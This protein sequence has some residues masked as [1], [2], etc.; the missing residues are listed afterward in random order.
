MALKCGMVKEIDVNL[1]LLKMHVQYQESDHVLNRAYNVLSGNIR[2]EDI[3]LNRQD[4]E[5]LNA[6]G[7]QRIPDPDD[8]G[9][10]YSAVYE[11]RYCEVDGVHKYRSASCM[12]RGKEGKHRRGTD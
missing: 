12:G 5:Y 6:V 10:F 11:R 2:L 7:A 8:S 3:E 9:R 4:E 1:E